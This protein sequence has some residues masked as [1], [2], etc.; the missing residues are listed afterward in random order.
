M[1]IKFSVYVESLIKLFFRGFGD[2]S[3]RYTQ[4]LEI[5]EIFLS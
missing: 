1:K 5:L 2:C 3:K 4:G